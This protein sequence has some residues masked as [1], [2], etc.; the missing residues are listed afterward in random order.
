MKQTPSF[1][2]KITQFLKL[3]KGTISLTGLNLSF[4]D[5][6][7]LNLECDIVNK[8]SYKVLKDGTFLIYEGTNRQRIDR[9][10]LC[11]NKVL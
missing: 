1:F 6:G 7:C 8:P 4:S 10:V 3:E 11:D 2:F 5:L 9:H